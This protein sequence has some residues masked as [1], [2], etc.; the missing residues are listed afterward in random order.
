MNGGVHADDIDKLI[1]VGEKEKEKLCA[2][3]DSSNSSKFSIVNPF[4]L[5]SVCK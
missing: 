2:D 3:H 4:V 1:V 5:Y